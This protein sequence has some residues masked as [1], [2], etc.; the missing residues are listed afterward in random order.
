VGIVEE[1]TFFTWTR[2]WGIGTDEAGWWLAGNLLNIFWLVGISFIKVSDVQ[3][4]VFTEFFFGGYIKCVTT[5]TL[6]P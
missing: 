5:S 2:N 4:L 3:H 1:A 6:I